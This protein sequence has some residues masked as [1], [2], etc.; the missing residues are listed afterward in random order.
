M[1]LNKKYYGEAVNHNDQIALEWARIPHFYS[2]FY[3]YK[4]ATGITSAVSIANSIL[5]KEG[6][7]D[8]YKQFLSAGSSASPYDILRITGVDLAKEEPFKIA[9]QEFEDTLAQLEALY[10]N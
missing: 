4:Y 10:E 3:V 2:S 9:M 7:V 8:K 5:T 1:Q 6:Y